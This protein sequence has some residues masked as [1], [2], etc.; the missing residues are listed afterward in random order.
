MTGKH[1]FQAPVARGA[2]DVVFHFRP[3]QVRDSEGFIQRVGFRWKLRRG[4]LIRTQV[5]LDGA[6]HIAVEGIELAQ[7]EM[8]VYQIHL[9]LG[10]APA[11]IFGSQEVFQ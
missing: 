1:W 11:L 2:V 10:D 4:N 3:V 6:I 5:L 7:S 8:R 9:R